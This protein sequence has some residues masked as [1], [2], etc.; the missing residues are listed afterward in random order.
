M[1]NRY[2]DRLECVWLLAPET[3]S[4][5][6]GVDGVLANAVRLQFWPF[7]ERGVGIH[8]RIRADVSIVVETEAG[9]KT[10]TGP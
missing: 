1:L 10:P 5:S 7:E 8:C 6:A 4:P 3:S 2:R 9:H